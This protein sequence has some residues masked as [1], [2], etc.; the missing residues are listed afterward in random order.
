[1]IRYDMSEYQNK[2]DIYR[3]IGSKTEQG[4]LTTA[5]RENPFSLLLFDEMEK[6]EPD[7]LNLFLQILDEGIMTDGAGKKVSFANT[8]I[9]AT[10]NAGSELIYQSIKD[11]VDFSQ[12]SAK[13]TSYIIDQH[14]FRAELL[15]RFSAVIAFAPLSQAEIVQIAKLMIEKLKKTIQEN[16]GIEVTVDEDAVMRLSE[17]GF[18]PEMGARPME[19]IIQEKLENLLADKILRK[20]LKDGDKYQITLDMIK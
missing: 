9:I 7:I 10:S 14:L 3:L 19:R 13:L 18:D 15:N 6:A 20:E 17:L 1:M 4:N 11:G 5:V 2:D 12:V 16:Q 8:I